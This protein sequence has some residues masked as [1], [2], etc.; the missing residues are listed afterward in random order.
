MFFIT[1]FFPANPFDRSFVVIFLIPDEIEKNTFY[2][3]NVGRKQSN[4]L[5]KINKQRDAEGFQNSYPT[6]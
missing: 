2:L 6:D 3:V 1:E 4:T 5:N